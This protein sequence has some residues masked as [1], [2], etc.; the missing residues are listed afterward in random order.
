M[1]KVYHTARYRYDQLMNIGWKILIPVSMAN[2]IV[3]GFLKDMGAMKKPFN[4]AGLIKRDILLG[5]RERAFPDFPAYRV[6][7]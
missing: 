1:D 2:I 5:F 4:I 3:T 7:A 6:E